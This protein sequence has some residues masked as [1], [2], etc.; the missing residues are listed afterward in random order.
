[1][2]KKKR[3]I[4]FLFSALIVSALLWI[5]LK[6]APIEIK[7]NLVPPSTIKALADQYKPTVVFDEKTL[8]YP[9]RFDGLKKIALEVDKHVIAEVDIT[10]SLKQFS[11]QLQHPQELF[12]SSPDHSIIYYYS[13]STHPEQWS[14]EKTLHS[15]PD[16]LFLYVNA[17]YDQYLKITYT[18][19][20]EGN[21]WRNH[22]RGDGAMFAI[23]FA[24][25]NGEYQP[26]KTRAY[27]HLQYSEVGYEENIV[28]TTQQATSPV[29]FV[30][31][32]SHST[33]HRAGTYED[34]DG[35][36]F[37]NVA[38]TTASGYTYC[39]DRTKLVFPDVTR[40][41][42]EK[43]AFLG[44]V[45]WGGSPNDRIYDKKD[46]MGKIPILR[47]LPLGNKSA[48]MS[49]DPSAVFDRKSYEPAGLN[50]KEVKI[51]CD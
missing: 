27:M 22:H 46:V 30:T 12:K 45:Y 31:S 40:N 44:E 23:Y 2:F 8:F 20:F 47:N 29:F 33:Y 39:N 25:Q 4:I 6:P 18:I 19:P 51:S 1:M 15:F 42:I 9:V 36:P 7:P 10:D 24:E 17:S 34:V 21:Q 16:T 5:I 28:S 43:W 41:N 11:N 50:L 37:L 13:L 32:G 14:S 38:E 26:I 48:K 35:I 49:Y 3:R